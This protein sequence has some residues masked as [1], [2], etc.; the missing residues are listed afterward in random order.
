M[1]QEPSQKHV[2]MIANHLLPGGIKPMA[3]LGCLPDCKRADHERDMIKLREEEM[4]VRKRE[5]E[6]AEIKETFEWKQN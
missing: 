6:K 5:Y 4:N 1:D 2:C 3:Y